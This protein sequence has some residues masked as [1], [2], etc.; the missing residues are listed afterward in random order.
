[1]AET[2]SHLADAIANQR[3]RQF[4]VTMGTSSNTADLVTGLKA[5]YKVVATP[6]N[7]AAYPTYVIGATVAGTS[8]VGTVAIKSGT[9]A[10]SYL[11]EVTGS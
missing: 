10:A 5:I 1:M 4:K 3:S 8:T 9:S 2:V 7:G 11:V 6:L